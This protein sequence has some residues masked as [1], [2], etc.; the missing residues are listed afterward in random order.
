MEMKKMNLKWIILF[1]PVFTLSLHAQITPWEAVPLMQKGINLGNTLEPPH[2]GDWGNPLT[3]EYY[4][5]MY[6]AAGF[7]TVRIPVRW[8]EHTQTIPPYHVD[9]TWMN[10]VEQIVDW[11]LSRGL[12]IVINAHHEEWI[13]ANY[14]NAGYRARF[15][16]IWSQIAVRFR[17]KSDRLF[18]EIINEPYGLTKAQNDDLHQRVLSIIRQTNPTRIVIFQGHNWGGSDELVTAAIPDDHYIMGS[19]HSYDPYLFGLEGQG[20]WG[21]TGDYSI[22]RNKFIT[23][24]NWSDAN[25]IPVFLGEFGAVKK[26]DY[27]SRMRHYRAYVEYAQIYGFISCAWDDGGDFRI[28]ERQA[29]TWNELKDIL[30][31]TTPESPV[32]QNLAVYQDT[33]LRLTWSNPVSDYDSILIQRRTEYTN[34]TNIDELPGDTTS[35]TDHNLTEKQYYYYRVIGHYS[36]T[37]DL[38]SQPV[39]NM[40]PVYIPKVRSYYLGE[41]AAVPGIVEAENFDVGGEGLTYHDTDDRNLPAEYRSSEAVDIFLIKDVGYEVGYAYPGEWL[42]YTLNVTQPGEYTVNTQVASLQ[43][44]GSFSIRIGDGEPDTLMVPK[45]GSWFVNA[46]VPA[47]MNLQAGTQ[48]M[49]FSILAQPDFHIDNFEFILNT[50]EDTTSVSVHRLNQPVLTVYQDPSSN[51]VVRMDNGPAPERIELYSLTGTLIRMEKPSNHEVTIPVSGIPSGVYI[52]R[53]LTAKGV[54]TGKTFIHNR[55]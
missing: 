32:I 23:V 16:S 51:L 21:S 48:I 34:Y 15:D 29:R 31:H 43:A 11:G 2:E 54:Y 35:F 37:G 53:A 41:P 46:S 9:D 33:L 42:E 7:Q 3:Q 18:F 30:V 12:F 39:R 55:P 4:F 19:F 17:D 38:Y 6:K 10:R 52:V 25:H 24:K 1:L 8:D 45:S 13:K 49:R 28:M 26:A 40:V 27:N 44:G 50:L 47:V 20:T 22:L 14:D 36:Q 5:D